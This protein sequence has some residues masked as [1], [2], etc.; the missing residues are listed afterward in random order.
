MIVKW[1]LD[2]GFVPVHDFEFEIDDEE[3]EGMSQEEIEEYIDGAVTDEYNQ[4]VSY[5]WEIEE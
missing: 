3:L 1:Y 4:T 2:D 5:Y